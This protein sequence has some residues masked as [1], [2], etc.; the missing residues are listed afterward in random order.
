MSGARTGRGQSGRP[1]RRKLN[2]TDLAARIGLSKGTVSRALN[3]YP[4]ISEETRRRVREAA[5][6]HGYS[7]SS[8]AQRL[9]KGATHTIGIVREANPAPMSEAFLGEFVGGAS[10][11]LGEHGYDL[12]FATPAPG[13]EPI[14]SYR[15]LLDDG[16]VD[17]FIIYRTETD[18]ARVAF[19]KGEGAPFVAHG[20]TR[21]ESGYAWLDTENEVA[22]YDA[23]R[24]LLALG[25]RKIALLGGPQNY[26]FSRLREAGYRRAMAEAGAERRVIEAGLAP[27]SGFAA[28]QALL[29]KGEAPTAILAITDAAA[30]G[31]IQA[32]GHAG[33]SVPKDLSVIGCDG[34][35]SAAWVDPPLTTMATRGRHAGRRLAEMLLT[36]LAGEDP[37]GLQELWRA[38][39]IRRSSDGPPPAAHS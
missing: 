39:L 7:P 27:A 6:A 16:R 32:A 24:H 36:L 34:V 19:L 28:C 31:V 11:A 3:N 29:G 1:T 18:D 33:L 20:R 12:L 37:A 26:N 2:I 21:D 15:R 14:E 10:A 9:A 25:H 17:G 4:D 35:E 5:I 23:T 8:F 38:E 22:F 30:L 13:E